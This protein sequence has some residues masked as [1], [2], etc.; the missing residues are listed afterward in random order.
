MRDQICPYL[1]ELRNMIYSMA[2]KSL[3]D[4]FPRGYREFEGRLVV[5]EPDAGVTSHFGFKTAYRKT[6]EPIPFLGFTQTCTLIRAEF[7]PQWI[8]AHRVPLFAV[9]GYLQAFYPEVPNAAPCGLPERMKT[10]MNPKATLLISMGPQNLDGLNMA[11]LLKHALR[12]PDM[13]FEVLKSGWRKGAGSQYD[14]YQ[15]GKHLPHMLTYHDPLWVRFLQEDIIVKLGRSPYRRRNISYDFEMLVDGNPDSEKCEEKWR[16]L[17]N[18][19][20]VPRLDRH[21]KW[22]VSWCKAK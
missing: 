14:I 7:R 22:S 9:E 18:A 13:T 15:I 19:M 2:L 11:P 6:D 17:Y 5:E 3:A 4:H 21:V 10:Y 16:Q 20:E 8:A 12:N 1:K